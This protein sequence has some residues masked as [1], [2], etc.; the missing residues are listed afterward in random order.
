MKSQN[1]LIAHPKTDEEVN[2]LKAFMKALKIKFEV[3]PESEYKPEFVE[4][5]LD[6]RKEAKEGKVTR[7]KKENL[8]DFLNIK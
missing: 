2:A 6:S 7:V 3:S 1:I 8:K 4:K 5:V